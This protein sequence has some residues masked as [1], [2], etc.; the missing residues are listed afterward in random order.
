YAL[1][2]YQT[3]YFKA[4][5]P[6]AFLAA[7]MTL[8]IH[9]TDKLNTFRQELDR[10]HI[11]LLPP[12]VN[13]SD[14][15][16]SVETGEDGTQAIRYALGAIKGVGVEAMRG[17][18]AAREAGGPFADPFDLAR[19]VD[20][21]SMNKRLWENMIR[22]GAF[23]ALEPNRARL[24]GAVDTLHGHGSAEAAER[25]SGQSSLFGGAGGGLETPA[26]PEIPDWDMMERLKHEFEAIGFYL[27]A[28]P[29][30]SF[31]TARVGA[32]PS[33]QLA[34]RVKGGAT[35][36][37]MAGVVMSKREMSTRNGGRMAFVVLSDASGVFEVTLFSE[38]LAAARPLLDG[39]TPLLLTVD[40][41][42]NGD[43]MRLTCQRIEPLDEAVAR[44]GLG[45]TIFLGDGKAVKPLHALLE[46]EGQGRGRVN[47][48]V[49]LGDGREAE[50]VLP[51]GY[52]IGAKTRA[53][54][55]STQGVVDV[56]EV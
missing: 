38:V 45:L 31:N 4:N 18:V 7:S 47:L 21:R 6:V 34:D 15:V 12:D 43:M 16:F 22:A 50:I 29:L 53:A 5:Y 33:G 23:D 39:G 54:L 40:L 13:R 44:S 37:K 1:V 35:Q 25:S 42:S 41:Q 11:A 14:P 36:I 52:A 2:D 56:R 3:A 20:L 55:R 10:L 49:P 17:L 9:N 24:H 48:M 8:D 30:D 26:L 32:V 19:R 27:S 46:R 28:H 51:R